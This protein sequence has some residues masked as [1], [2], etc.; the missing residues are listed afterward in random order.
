MFKLKVNDEIFMIMKQI[1]TPQSHKGHKAYFLNNY[2]SIFCVLCDFVVRKL[3]L[4][5][6]TQR[7]C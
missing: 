7:L 1:Y 6:V 4:L 3:I 5:L 2:E